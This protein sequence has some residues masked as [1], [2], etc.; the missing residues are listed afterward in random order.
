M[1]ELLDAQEEPLDV[2]VASA[3]VGPAPAGETELPWPQLFREASLLC[4]VSSISSKLWVLNAA[5]ASL[6]KCSLEN[7]HLCPEQGY[8]K[9]CLEQEIMT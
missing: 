5:S 1:Q 6:C 8:M 7:D 4:C 3:S 9:R 2:C